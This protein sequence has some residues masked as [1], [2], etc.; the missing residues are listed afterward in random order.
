MARIASTCC[1]PEPTSG[2]APRRAPA[3]RSPRTRSASPSCGA[4]DASGSSRGTAA[5][6]PR[7]WPRS[8]DQDVL[9]LLD[10]AAPARSRAPRPR[11]RQ[12]AV[13]VAAHQ[14]RRQRGG[15][16]GEPAL[17][18][19]SQVRSSPPSAA[20]STRRGSG[21][22]APATAPGSSPRPGAAR[23]DQP[24]GRGRARRRDPAP[25]PPPPRRR[26]AI[27]IQVALGPRCRGR[28]PAG[29]GRAPPARSALR[30]A[31]RG[32]SRGGGLGGVCRRALGDEVE[33]V[34]VAV[35]AQQVLAAPP[36][37]RRAH[38]DRAQLVEAVDALQRDP[39]S[40]R[41]PTRSA[42]SKSTVH[43]SP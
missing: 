42:A 7:Q 41:I 32:S 40:I 30:S 21:R 6:E 37:G 8:V 19:R 43:S 26:R 2:A 39:Q 34:R 13:G 20:A 24:A 27:A 17:Q 3:T 22:R 25:A 33:P 15:A 31:P 1:E 12:H 4:S 14:Q 9:H 16:A 35:R 11:D 23:P 10:P 36:A 29:A 38:A 18:S 28:G 5:T